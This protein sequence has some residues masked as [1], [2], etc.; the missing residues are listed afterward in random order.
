M[1]RQKKIDEYWADLKRHVALNVTTI[2]GKLKA[3]RS[4]PIPSENDF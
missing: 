2:S 1:V 3:A 4:T